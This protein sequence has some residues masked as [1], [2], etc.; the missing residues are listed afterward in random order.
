MKSIDVKSS[1]Y[2]DFNV[3]TNN[4]DHKL[5]AGDHMR[6][7]KYIKIFAKVYIAIWSEEVFGIKKVKT[8]VP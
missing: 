5:E 2:I 3:K 1:T 7:L 8:T 4:K 6:K